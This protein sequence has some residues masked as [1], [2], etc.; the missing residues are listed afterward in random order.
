MCI[1]DSLGL[2][3]ELDAEPSQVQS[4]DRLAQLRDPARGGVVVVAGVVRGF[5]ELLDGG[6]GRRDVRVAET[7]VDHVPTGPARLELEAVDDRED[8]R[9]KAQDPAELHLAHHDRRLVLEPRAGRF[10]YPRAGPRG[11]GP[12]P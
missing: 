8:V 5:R 7:E 1:R 10:Y 2:G 4:R 11:A 3:V 12:L 6:V 9:G